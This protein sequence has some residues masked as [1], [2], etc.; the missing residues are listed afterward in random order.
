MKKELHIVST[1]ILEESLALQLMD[2][3]MKVTQSDF[4]K[5][6]IQIPE[7]IGSISIN[8]AIVLTSKTAVEAWMEIAKVVP[9]EVLKF[10]V[11]C[12]ESATQYKAREYGL[13]IAGVAKDA[14]SLAALILDDKAISAITFICGNL[15]RDELP[16]LLKKGNVQVLE[17]EAYQTEPISIKIEKPYHG[18]LFFSPSAINSFLSLNDI[19]SSVAFCLGETTADQARA[20]GFSEIQLA[21]THTPE[22]LIQTVINFYKQPVHA[23]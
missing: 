20:V 15:R 21:A 8:P 9:K 11:H 17:I 6:T 18:V 19:D 5:K 1:K 7:N 12:L 23:Q 3:G 4:I 16:E 14:R 10:P 22:S 2:H 13:K